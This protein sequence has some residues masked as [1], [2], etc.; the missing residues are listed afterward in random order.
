MPI[1]AGVMPV[2]SCSQIE[3]M[4]NMCGATL[5]VRLRKMLHKYEN[6]RAAILD[7]G[8]AYTINQVVDLIANNVDGV[9]IYTMNNPD[10]ARK[11]CNGIKNLI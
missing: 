7:A 10:V 4:V 8:I 6:N 5:P 1:D 3:R 9:H 2:T 11:I